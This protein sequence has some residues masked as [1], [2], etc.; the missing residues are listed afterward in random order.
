[1]KVPESRKYR[2]CTNCIMDTTDSKI[3]F[4]E[5]GV[6]QYCQNYHDVLL[7]AW[8]DQQTDTKGRDE[9]ISRIKTEGKNKEHDCIIGI[10]GGLDSSYVA[11][12]A[13][14]KYGLRPLLF[15]CDAGWNSDIGVSNIQKIVRS[16]GLDLVTEVINWE[17][18]KDMQRAFF[19]S[20]VAF[21][22]MPQDLALFSALYKFAAKNDFKYVITGG[23][24]STE[25]VR[26]SIEWTYFSTDTKHAKDIHKRFGERPLRTFPMCDIF[27]YKSYYR[28]VKRIKVV[29]LLDYE[30]FLK[31]EATRALE[32]R[33]DWVRYPQKH[34][35]SRF[36]RF[37]ESFWTVRKFG[38]DK[39]RAYF[40]SLILTNQM[41]RHEALERIS[42]PELPE[43]VMQREFEY[44]ANK[45]DWSK[46]EFQEIFDQK[47]RSFLDYA[48]NYFWIVLFARLANIFGFDKRLFK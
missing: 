4:D 41:T 23:N 26:E 9:L 43:E 7:P 27:L 24:N 21:Q 40:S 2:I 22:D 42:V 37:Y 48:N 47:N 17:E 18:M 30:R 14:E 1:M 31:E 38:Y 20:Q 13:K 5:H 33:F 29:K 11:W 34:Y 19:R 44:V 10:S 35:E 6:C 45:L 12:Q 25:C 15:H 28:W 46:D 39:R 8:E 3:S 16:L 36:T 32:E